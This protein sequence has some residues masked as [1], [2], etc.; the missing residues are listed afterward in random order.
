MNMLMAA[1]GA[2]LAQGAT[3]TDEILVEQGIRDTL[4]PQGNVVSVDMVHVQDRMTGF[5]MVRLTGKDYDS[6]FACRSW[7]AGPVYD[8]E[9]RP[10]ITPPVLREMEAAIRAEL[11]KDGRVERVEMRRHNDDDHMIGSAL[12]HVRDGTALQLACT[13]SRVESGTDAAFHFACAPS[14]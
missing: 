14:A 13:A 4:A 2:L 8:F 6:R 12:L 9:C 10:E 1:L 3:L 11:E 7:L 5:A